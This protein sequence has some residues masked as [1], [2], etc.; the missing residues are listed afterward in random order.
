VCDSCRV[1][2]TGLNRAKTYYLQ[3]ELLAHFKLF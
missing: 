2:L 3:L 1:Y